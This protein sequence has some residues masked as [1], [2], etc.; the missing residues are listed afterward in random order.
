MDITLIRYLVPA[1]VM[2]CCGV[3][4]FLTRRNMIAMLISL[5][6]MLNAV[7]INFV[8]FNRYLFP[9]SMEGMD[10]HPLRNRHRSSR[11]RTRNRHHHQPLP[12]KQKTLTS[13]TQQNEKLIT[14]YG[15]YNTYSYIG[16]PALHVPPLR[17]GGSQDESQ[18][19]RYARNAR[20]GNRVGLVYYT[21]FTY[22]FSGNPEFIDG[23]TRLQAVIF[24]HTWLQFT[25]ALAIRI[26]FLLDDLSHDAHC[27]PDNLIHGPRLLA[28]LHTRRERLP[29]LLRLP[30]ALQLL[31][32]RTRCSD[33]HFPDVHLLGSS[34]AHHRSLL[35]GF[36][37][38]PSAVSACRRPSSSPVSAF[39]MF[40]MYFLRVFVWTTPHYDLKEHH[41]HLPSF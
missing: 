38:T 22:Y 15:Y 27:H 30:F 29:A 35:I 10:V 34:W 32:A 6:L 8:V 11:D 21:A 37:Y 41:G 13:A 5:E 12:G 31:D 2:F 18:T 9:S 23:T 33:Q 28:R 17:T 20:H 26:G 1:I 7:D 16:N 36:F 24:N 39:Y 25:P 4:G 40:R 14:P 19:R 3:Y